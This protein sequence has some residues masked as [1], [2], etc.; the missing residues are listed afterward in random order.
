[1]ATRPLPGAREPAAATA[2]PAKRGLRRVTGLRH[3]SPGRLQLLLAV[4]LGLAAITG[5]GAGLTGGSAAA[6]TSDLGN[7]A[8]PLLV[9][10]E[11]IYS[12][13][14]DADT[15]A[16]QAFLTGG[17]EPV[18]LT[19]RYDD[20]LARATTALTSAA[21]RTADD[22]PAATA[23]RTLSTGVARYAALVAT[24]R[25]INRQGLPVGASYLSAASELHRSVLL[26]Q[27]QTLFETAQRE[28][29]AGYRSARSVV[30]VTVLAVLLLALAGALVWAQRYLSRVTRRTFNV[31]LLGATA[32]TA[33][34][35]IGALIVLTGQQV[36]L[37]RAGET[38]STPAVQLAEARILAL[39]ER[40]DEALKLAAHGSGNA[41]EEAKEE[42]RDRAVVAGATEA[43]N[44]DYLDD[45]TR[46]AHR[47]YVT[48]HQ[49]VRRLDKDGDYDGAVRTALDPATT[50]AF[51]TVR[52]GIGTALA[53]R[54]AAFTGEIDRAARG[55]GLLTILG[56]LAALGIC[57]LAGA[58]IRARLEEYR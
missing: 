38:G 15:T 24:A 31:P 51:D 28:V 54:K 41:E 26:P 52:A 13:L 42:T 39:R 33:L 40:G 57:L 17:L 14:A 22:G 53:E 55:L 18:A 9:E 32:L 58:G 4:L 45:A 56:P 48:A 3:S 23:I 29:D 27:A 36:H 21:R 6:G 47:S 10:A 19:R 37:H 2:P 1:M 49:S 35:A 5:I 44:N 34:L 8:Q 20:D 46:A 12:A 16:A 30:W 25:S 11:T 43:M 7:R 50:T